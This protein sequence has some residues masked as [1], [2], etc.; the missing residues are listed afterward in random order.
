MFQCF[1]IPGSFTASFNLSSLLLIY[2]K[3]NK[4]TLAQIVPILST[5]SPA[6]AL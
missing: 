1:K 5:P 3:G 4:K 6:S 2:Y